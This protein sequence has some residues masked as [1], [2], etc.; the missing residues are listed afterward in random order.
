LPPSSPHIQSFHERIAVG[1]SPIPPQQLDALA[2]A[3]APAVEA[4]QAREGGALSHFEIV[5]ALAFKHFQEQ[6]VGRWAGVW[7]DVC[8]VVVVVVGGGDQGDASLTGR[9]QRT[10]ALLRCHSAA[11]GSRAVPA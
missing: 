7:V 9:L 8:V 11:S 6:Q 10:T 3:H 4:A 5:T 2:A 1:G